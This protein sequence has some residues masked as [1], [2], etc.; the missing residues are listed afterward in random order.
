[1]DHAP[2]RG[3]GNNWFSF[4]ARPLSVLQADAQ[5]PAVGK[6][7]PPNESITRQTGKKLDRWIIAIL[8]LAVILFL[9]DKLVLHKDASANRD[10]AAATSAEKS[11]AVLPF[12]NMTSVKENEYFDP[13][14]DPLRGDPRFQALLKSPATGK[15]AAP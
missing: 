12:V 7:N 14:W 9:A 15:S 11:I 10:Q 5:R 1:M 8:A 2:D 13:A 3:R 6:R 4:R